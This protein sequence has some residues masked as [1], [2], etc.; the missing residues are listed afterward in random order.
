MS[1]LVRY[2]LIFLFLCNIFFQAFCNKETSETI[3]NVKIIDKK[4]GTPVEGAVCYIEFYNKEGNNTYT[5]PQSFLSD[6][7]GK[8]YFSENRPYDG[9][10][11]STVTKTGYNTH[12][13]LGIKIGTVNNLEIK[14]IPIDGILRLKIVNANGL[15][16]S[17]WVAL[18]N[19][20][21]VSESKGLTSRTLLSKTPTTLLQSDSIVECFNF[22]SEEFTKIYWDFTYYNDLQSAMFRDSI[23]LLLHDTVNYTILF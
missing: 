4:S 19:P 14:L 1:N 10:S 20:S 2:F 7:D 18:E 12:V 6:Q 23:F 21:L 9:I 8:V 22:T 11:F 17:V 16:D 13:H 3:V 15:H 5:E